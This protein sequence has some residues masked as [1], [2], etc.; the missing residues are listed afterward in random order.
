M[1]SKCSVHVSCIW[2]PPCIQ[3]IGRHEYEVQ[4][5]SMNQEEIRGVVKGPWKSTYRN[6]IESESPLLMCICYDEATLYWPFIGISTATLRIPTRV[7]HG[8][9]VAAI[10]QC[11]T[12][13]SVAKRIQAAFHPL[14]TFLGL[15]SWWCSFHSFQGELHRTV[16]VWVADAVA[17]ARRQGEC[18]AA[19]M[20]CYCCCLF[21]PPLLLLITLDC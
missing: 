5:L 12:M 13:L 4:A 8:S 19:V 2:C 3:T 6:W 10:D 16:E 11:S 20:V 1:C 18:R 9:G 21:H 14:I 7:Q 15:L 17:A